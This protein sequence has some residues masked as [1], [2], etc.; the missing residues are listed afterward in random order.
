MEKINIGDYVLA[1]KWSD[2]GPLD[3]WVVGFYNG[4]I[5][6]YGDKYPRF[7]VVDAEKKQFRGNGFRRIKRISKKRGGSLLANKSYIG[8]FGKSLWSWLRM[9]YRDYPIK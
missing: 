3:H 1:T 9:P 6:N 8:C 5:D 7:D 2:G 4:K